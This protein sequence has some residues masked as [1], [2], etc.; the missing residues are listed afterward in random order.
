MSDF[1]NHYTYDKKLFEDSYHVFYLAHPSAAPDLKCIVSLSKFKLDPEKKEARRYINSQMLMAT[2]LYHPFIT[3]SWQH[4]FV[5]DRLYSISEYVNGQSVY[6]KMDVH[7]QLSIADALKYAIDVAHALVYAHSK[8]ITHTSLIAPNII[9]EHNTGRVVIKN[10]RE[11]AVNEHDD[12][13]RLARKDY[14]PGYSWDKYF[15][16]IGKHPFATYVGNDVMQFGLFLFDCLGGLGTSVRDYDEFKPLKKLR[17]EVPSELEELISLCMNQTSEKYP[18]S[19]MYVLSQLY[20]FNAKLAPDNNI[21]Q[22]REDLLAESVPKKI[23]FRSERMESNITDLGPSVSQMRSSITVDHS[24]KKQPAE[25][26][27]EEEEQEEDLRVVHEPRENRPNAQRVNE[28]W[29]KAY[30]EALISKAKAQE[31]EEGPTTAVFSPEEFADQMMKAKNKNL[32][33]EQRDK[34]VADAKKK[35]KNPSFELDSSMSYGGSILVP[36]PAKAKVEVAAWKKMPHPKSSKNYKQTRA[37]TFAGFDEL[38]EKLNVTG[39]EPRS[40]FLSLLITALFL[41]MIGLIL[42]FHLET[43]QILKEQEE[44]RIKAYQVGVSPNV[45]Q[46]ADYT[47]PEMLSGLSGNIQRDLPKKTDQIVIPIVPDDMVFIPKGEFKHGTPDRLTTVYLSGYKIDRNEV[48][49]AAYQKCIDAKACRAFDQEELTQNCNSLHADRGDHP[50]NCV[51]QRD[52]KTYCLWRNKRLPTEAEWEKAAR[53]LT[54]NRYVTG[55]LFPNCDNI[56]VS[57]DKRPHCSKMGTTPVQ[58]MK[59]D[60]SPFKVYDMAGNVLEYVSDYYDANYYQNPVSPNPKGPTRGIYLTA[61]GSAWNLNAAPLSARTI[62]TPD[63][64]GEHIGFRCAEDVPNDK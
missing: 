56:T 6:R 51:T 50:I 53:G 42:K 46:S 15:C 32:S 34:T 33:K 5:K 7:P 28:D 30:K 47:M 22:V 12:V 54:A 4:G 37:K 8:G 43:K 52:A 64:W 60:I 49:V 41:F 35:L 61:K 31:D 26:P 20:L 27:V 19:M 18:V 59:A 9:I 57:D 63:T 2:E 11:R 58:S 39:K 10:F 1:I 3:K 21:N 48:T 25:E 45:A 62:I 38:F 16:T 40:H 36:E 17:P 29:E 14:E 24:A 44:L 55:N 13:I 23:L